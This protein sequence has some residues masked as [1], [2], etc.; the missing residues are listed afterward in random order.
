MAPSSSSERFQRP[1]DSQDS[2]HSADSAKLR[3]PTNRA[4]VKQQFAVALHR[5][6]SRLP[7]A[8]GPGQGLSDW[9]AE[10]DFRHQV[11]PRASPT[12]L[13]RLSRGSLCLPC[14]DVDTHPATHRS[15][16]RGS[17]RYRGEECHHCRPRRHATAT[18]FPAVH[19]PAHPPAP[20]MPCPPVPL[21]PT[22]RCCRRDQAQ[23]HPAL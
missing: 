22:P 19:S 15:K 14:A 12:M 17:T 11:P 7:S 21:P 6:F 3:A 5:N 9:A 23:A 13:T 8:G 4:A 1:A 20:R 10:Y 16:S 18:C 2:A